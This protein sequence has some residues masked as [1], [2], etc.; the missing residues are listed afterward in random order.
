M[1][2]ELSKFSFDHG[3]ADRAQLLCPSGTKIY[4]PKT[5]GYVRTL[6]KGLSRSAELPYTDR[7]L[8]LLTAQNVISGEGMKFAETLL[9]FRTLC[10][11][12]PSMEAQSYYRRCFG[13]ERPLFAA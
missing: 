5:L 11:S 2:A 9:L 13:R 12:S 10:L 6:E 1:R 4:L 3:N 8:I 7:T